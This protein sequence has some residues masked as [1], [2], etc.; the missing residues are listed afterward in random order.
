MAD[1]REQIKTALEDADCSHQADYFRE[2]GVTVVDCT[3]CLTDAVVS[4]VEPILWRARNMRGGR[5]RYC[6]AIL[7]PKS[8]GKSTDPQPHRMSCRHHVG[9]LEHRWVHAI[10]SDTFGGTDHECVCGRMVRTGGWASE[11]G[12]PVCPDAGLDWRGERST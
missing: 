4:T 1:L 8:M 6:S 9:P 12:E 5:C 7:D 11:E 3:D 2:H 10:P